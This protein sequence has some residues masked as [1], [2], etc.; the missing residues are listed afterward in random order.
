LQWSSL[1]QRGNL[2]EAHPAP[3]IATIAA[4][5]AAAAT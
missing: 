2:G 5:A 3:A 4:K 1:S